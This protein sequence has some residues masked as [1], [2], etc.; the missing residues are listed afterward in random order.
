[1]LKL[2][3]FFKSNITKLDIQLY[4]QSDAVKL[5]FG[6]VYRTD[7]RELGQQRLVVKRENVW[8]HP[9]YDSNQ[10]L[11]DIALIKLP[12]DILFDEYIQPAKLPDP[13]QLYDNENAVVSGWGKTSGIS[14]FY[15][16]KLS[17]SLQCFHRFDKRAF[18]A[19]YVFQCNSLVK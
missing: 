7:D 17:N 19:S 18:R 12:A 5:Y 4:S 3:R 14:L 8:I 1:V 13:N 2:Y 15:S 9:Q 10:D 11:N 16:T 6:A